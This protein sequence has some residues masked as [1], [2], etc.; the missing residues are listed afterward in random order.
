MKVFLPSIDTSRRQKIELSKAGC[1]EKKIMAALNTIAEETIPGSDHREIRK[2]FIIF[3]LTFIVL[4]FLVIIFPY[5]IKDPDSAVY[6]QI[7]QELAYVPLKHWC[8]P[9][10][11]GHDNDPLH[12]ELFIDHPPVLFWII[13]FFIRAGFP[14]RKAGLGVNF[15]FIFLSLYFLFSLGKKVK[16]YTEGWAFI[17][18]YVFSPIFLLY[19]IRANQ[20]H[21]M[22]L[23]ILAGIY[24]FIRSDES[25]KYKVLFA[26]SFVL[27][28]FIKGIMSFLL[29]ILAVFY[30]LFFSRK[31]EK[32]GLIFFSFFI[33]LVFMGLFEIWYLEVTGGVSFWKNYLLFQGTSTLKFGFNFAQIIASFFWYL[34]RA[35]FFASPWVFFLPQAI[36]KSIK[37]DGLLLQNRLFQFFLTSA[38]VII[39]FFS[40]IARRA[41]RYIFSSYCFLIIAG[42]LALLYL[43]PKIGHY[44][45]AKKKPFPL[46]LSLALI[47]LTLLRI[48]FHT[49]HYRFIKF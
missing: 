47:L 23:A 2:L 43:K 1:Q 48:Y 4:C 36:Y 29:L 9:L 18:G 40:L 10:W 44:L 14:G 37:S 25:W 45:A 13:A 33:G 21:P 31:R 27:A 39:L 22:N 12:P 32:L 46:Y 7:G 34:S 19:L 8:A 38:S 3:S 30:W 16:G 20:E 28:L 24:G 6:S 26:L 35:L 17:Y 15:L 41:D 11:Q 49:H 5:E 42:I